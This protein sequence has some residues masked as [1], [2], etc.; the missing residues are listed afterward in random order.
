PFGPGGPQVDDVSGSIWL[1]YRSSGLDPKYFVCPGS[2]ADAYDPAVSGS[3]LT[4]SNF[5][6][7]QNLS[8]S[9]ECPYPTMN[10]LM[11]RFGWD[12]SSLSS[13]FPLAADMN[14]GTPALLLVTPTS[15]ASQMADAN[16]PNHGRIGQNVLY[17]DY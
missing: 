5:T 9:F 16:S 14:P 13:D 17:G 12:N 15:S 7:R 4:K 3:P 6:S 11:G 8:Y 1:L 10:S 2:D